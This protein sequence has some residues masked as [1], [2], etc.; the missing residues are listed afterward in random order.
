[1]P[2]LEFMVGGNR[3][4]SNSGVGRVMNKVRRWSDLPLNLDDPTMDV[5][6]FN[7][8][9]GMEEDLEFLDGD[10]V[11]KMVDGILSITFSDR[12]HKYI[13]RKMSPRNPVQLMEDFSLMR[14]Q[15]DEDVNKVLTGDLWVV[16]I[17]LLGLPKGY[18]SDFLL[19]VTGLSIKLV[20]KIDEHTDRASEEVERQHRGKVQNTGAVKGDNHY[21]KARGSHFSMLNEDMGGDDTDKVSL[22]AGGVGNK[23]P[24]AAPLAQKIQRA[25][26]K[27][28]VIGSRPKLGSKGFKPK[29]MN[30]GVKPRQ[31]K[32]S[33]DDGV[34][35]GLRSST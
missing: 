10:V 31:E 28:F 9:V 29:I 34:L 21:V 6:G 25:K 30:L 11:T 23:E 13:K 19:H 20:V 1:M 15:D 26:G 16:W 4:G 3:L 8:S 12:V 22:V 5:N 27:D 18:Y 2:T 32:A 14:F 33:F 17:R 24:K 35:M 7:Q